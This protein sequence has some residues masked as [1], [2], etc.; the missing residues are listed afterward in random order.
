MAAALQA[1]GEITAHLV[2]RDGAFRRWT[3]RPPAYVIP[4]SDYVI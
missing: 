1:E 2:P 4:P 3:I